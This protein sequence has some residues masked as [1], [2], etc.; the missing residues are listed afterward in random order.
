MFL[1]FVREGAYMSQLRLHFKWNT[2]YISVIGGACSTHGTD[3]SCL[4]RF[5]PGVDRGIILK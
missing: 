5:D 1:S 4:Q 2:L 3:E